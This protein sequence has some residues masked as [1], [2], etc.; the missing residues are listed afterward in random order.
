MGFGHSKENSGIN[1][2]WIDQYID[3]YE[4]ERYSR[5]LRSMKSLIVKLFKNVDDAIKYMIN[6]K[7]EEFKVIVSGRL[8]SEFVRKFKENIND[9]LISPKI[10]VFT[11]SEDRFLEYNPEYKE[12]K[13]IFYTYGG[14]ATFFDAVIEFIQRKP[15]IEK[16]EEFENL[17]NSNSPNNK[18]LIFEYIEQKDNLPVS[19]D[20][21]SLL[22]KSLL[23]DL[24]KYNQLL[25]NIYSRENE[26]VQKLLEQIIFMKKIP[27]EILS[28]YYIRFYSMEFKFYRDINNQPEIHFP[29]IK[30]LYEAVKLKSLPLPS[31]SKLYGGT[32]LS[33]V[34]INKI[35]DYMKTK[36]DALPKSIVFSKTFLKF[37][38]DRKIAESFFGRMLTNEYTDVIFILE[39]EKN[40]DFNLFSLCYIEKYS[41]YPNEK[42]V[43]VFPFS[44]FEIKDV[45][46]VNFNGRKIYEIRILYLGKYLKEIDS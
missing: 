29:F 42:E 40:L 46:E 6:I 31:N 20:F 3:N 36:S 22:D 33:N 45:K 39:I 24:E 26:N 9:M 10:I 30:V 14:I 12:E 17:N 18:E 13:N 35:L 2:I 15:K 5:I 27:I 4:N 21:K 23:N 16:N 43:L 8:Y 32:K 34:E 7:F 41:F 28:K 25:Y 1:V 11:G 37:F 19:T 38:K 44:S